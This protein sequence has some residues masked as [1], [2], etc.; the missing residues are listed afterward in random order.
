M[1]DQNFDVII[2]GGSGA[3]LSA[4]M[5]LGR[6]R[7]KTLVID[8]GRPCNAV[9][10][11]SHN[12]LTHD[13]DSPASIRQQALKKIR[14]YPE[15]KIHFGTAIKT[16]K[17]ETGFVVQTEAGDEFTAQKL[18]FANGLTDELPDIKGFKACWG[19]TALHCPYCHGYEFI[20]QPTGLILDGSD[21]LNTASIIHNL[22]LN[23]VV[24]TNGIKPLSPKQLQTL[25][26]NKI[27]IIYEPIAEIQHRN[28]FVQGVLFADGTSREF[29][30]LYAHTNRLYHSA[31][32]ESLGFELGNSGYIIRNSD[33]KTNVP[34]VYACGE[35]SGAARSVAVA[36]A[37]GNIAGS[38]VNNDLCREA[39]LGL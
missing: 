38:T 3:G 7:R 36:V 32:A 13:G 24:M 4:A 39:F 8:N 2:V 10:R 34:G 17:T 27:E 11:A 21:F 19:I 16:L 31:L 6:S 37:G 5:V 30:V 1:N 23:F 22:S 35:V 29:N 25:E 26:R 12:F 14:V 33:M 15:V 20:N 28:G 18:V 9:A